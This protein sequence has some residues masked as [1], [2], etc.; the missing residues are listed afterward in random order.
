M[1]ATEVARFSPGGT[2][3]WIPCAVDD[4]GDSILL[5]QQTSDECRL[6]N[7][8]GVFCD[9]LPGP[10]KSAVLRRGGL[11]ILKDLGWRGHELHL[12]QIA[13]GHPRSWCVI[14]G[15]RSARSCDLQILN[16]EIIVAVEEEDRTRVFKV[17]DA[18]LLRLWEDEPDERRAAVESLGR[19]RYWQGS[20]LL[21]ESLGDDDADVRIAVVHALCMIGRTDALPHLL[22][23]LGRRPDEQLRVALESALRN[24][25]PRYLMWAVCDAITQPDISYRR[26]AALLCCIVPE[27]D[28]S[29]E[30]DKLIQDLDEQTRRA[31][32]QGM[33]LRHNSR[34]CL[35]L[36]TRLNDASKAVRRDAWYA[37]VQTLAET[38]FLAPEASAQLTAPLGLL[39]YAQDVLAAGRV[40]GFCRLWHIA[41]G[42][43]SRRSGSGY[44]RWRSFSS[45]HPKCHRGV[46]RAAQGL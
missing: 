7:R 25:H 29:D 42:R 10:A 31:A 1:S 39:T 17:V 2:G 34:F 20:E 26:G 36:L 46:D 30:L 43:L 23:A 38:G 32:V 3:P 19:R 14:P 12:Y 41:C 15:E 4:A 9:I 35:A 45:R 28:V 11:A 6:Y 37:L 16:G 21:A 40:P 24:F 22:Q 27:L 5:T 44:W 8:S 18:D 33:K 13:N